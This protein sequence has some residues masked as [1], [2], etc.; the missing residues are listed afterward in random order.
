MSSEGSMKSNS[1]TEWLAWA[2]VDPLFAISTVPG[3]EREGAHPWTL[4]DFYESGA[5]HWSIYRNEWKRYGVDFG[6]CLDL[7][8][9]AGRMTKHIAEDFV[10]VYGVDISP[11]MLNMARENVGRAVFLD[12]DGSSIPLSNDSVSAVFCVQVFQHLDCRDMALAYFREIYRVL[13]P[14]GTCLIQIPLIILPFERVWPLMSYIE[15]SLWTLSDAW[16]SVKARAKRWLIVHRGRKPFYRVL[17]YEPSWLFQHLSAIGFHDIHVSIFNA[18][19]VP[20][21]EEPHLFARK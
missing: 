2:K 1:N 6:A 3:R 18:T 4:S 7:G 20:S 14:G 10:S 5:V 21:E 16:L 12:C 9:G 17:Q 19:G 15:R 8:C 13:S 11:D